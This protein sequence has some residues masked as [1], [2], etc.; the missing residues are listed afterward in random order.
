MLANNFV[1]SLN[2]KLFNTDNVPILQ[3]LFR[4]RAVEK[5]QITMNLVES[6]VEIGGEL[7]GEVRLSA[8]QSGV[9]LDGVDVAVY[10]QQ[11]TEDPLEGSQVCQLRISE[12]MFLPPD[13]NVT[14]NFKKKLPYSTPLSGEKCKYY[15]VAS[16]EA[17]RGEERTRRE[18]VV[19]P[20]SP[21]KL[22]KDA[23]K[24]LG[25]KE[26]TPTGEFIN[27]CEVIRY[28]PTEFMSEVFSELKL[29]V[30]SKEKELN[31]TMEA[32]DK[33]GGGRKQVKFLFPCASM[34]SLTQVT[35]S[36]KRILNEVC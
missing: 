23:F 6:C 34:Q 8:G 2:Q 12:G 35:E 27:Q 20:N 14:L 33:Q 18:L 13:S 21:L 16:C 26:N 4:G 3:R 31:I 24:A 32:T 15:V 22:L 28:I 17:K 9:Q 10:L 19:L 7:R 11:N 25:F 29:F 30:G 1:E 5:A 36:F